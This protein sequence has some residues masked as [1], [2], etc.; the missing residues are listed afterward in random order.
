MYLIKCN[1]TN[2]ENF[3]YNLI[4][5]ASIMLLITAVVRNQDFRNGGCLITKVVNNL[6][7]IKAISR[8]LFPAKRLEFV[9]STKIFFT[10]KMKRWPFTRQK[11]YSVT[12][13][14]LQGYFWD[15]GKISWLL[16]L[17]YI[18]INFCNNKKVIQRAL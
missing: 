9:C 7:K 12:S 10:L 5:C 6:S 14:A 17:S 8:F 1:S 13:V 16:I 11:N 18:L 15:A 2:R 4:L 3:P